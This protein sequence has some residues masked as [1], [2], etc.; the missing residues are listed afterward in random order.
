MAMNNIRSASAINPV[1][2][3]NMEINVIASR[4]QLTRCLLITPTCSGEKMGWAGKT[5]IQYYCMIK[6]NYNVRE[7]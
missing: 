4:K 1:T 3:D 7:N 5:T 2:M 6:S